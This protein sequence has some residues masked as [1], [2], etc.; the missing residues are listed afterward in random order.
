MNTKLL[1]QIESV[2]NAQVKANKVN[3]LQS[4]SSSS[5]ITLS[6]SM[7]T[8]T[9]TTPYTTT[10]TTSGRSTVET[11]SGPTSGSVFVPRFRP[12]TTSFLTRHMASRLNIQRPSSRRTFHGVSKHLDPAGD[13]ISMDVPAQATKVVVPISNQQKS[14]KP[15][16]SSKK[17]GKTNEECPEKPVQAETLVNR[18]QSVQS[19]TSRDEKTYYVHKETCSESSYTGQIGYEQ[20][21]KQASEQR[22]DKKQGYL[23]TAFKSA[24]SSVLPRIVVCVRKRPKNRAEIQRNDL[25]ILAI[26]NTDHVVICEPRQRFDLTEYVESTAFRFDHCF[27]ENATTAEVYEYT[28]APMVNCIFQGYMATCFAY[29]QTGSGKTFTMAGPKGETTNSPLIE[30]GIYGMVV[31]DLFACYK[32]GHYAERVTISVNFFEI[33]CNKVNDLLNAK[34]SLRVM[35]DSFGS[36]Q[37]MGLREYIVDDKKTTLALIKHGYLQR[38]NGRT[39]ANENSSRSHAIFQIN[40][41]QRI[42][43]ECPRQN[44][45]VDASRSQATSGSERSR[46]NFAQSQINPRLSGPLVGRFSLVDLAGNERSADGAITSDRI[47]HMES[48]EINKSLLAL[49][50]CIRAMG[51]NGTSYLPFRTSKLTQVL[52]ESFIGKRSKT[53]MIAT[54][55][56]GLSCYE[57][58]MN[59]LRYAQRVK[60]LQPSLSV[61]KRDYDCMFTEIARN[62]E[63]TKQAEKTPCPVRAR[64]RRPRLDTDNV[65]RQADGKSN[66]TRRRLRDQLRSPSESSQSGVLVTAKPLTRSP[67]CNTYALIP[68][69]GSSASAYFSPENVHDIRDSNDQLADY[70]DNDQIDLKSTEPLPVP[71]RHFCPTLGSVLPVEST[72]KTNGVRCTA[73]RSTYSR[74]ATSS[75]QLGRQSLN[76]GSRLWRV[77][78]QKND[79]IHKHK[80]FVKNLPKWIA[81][82]QRLLDKAHRDNINMLAYVDLLTNRLSKDISQL[83]T[84]QDDAIFLRSLQTQAQSLSPN[85]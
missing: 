43:D 74:S 61:E 53:C 2:I 26:P 31:S 1:E 38:T 82:H 45:P 48:G 21:E 23:Q 70:S 55:S 67:S 66:K 78:R 36:V 37:V 68:L 35:E 44:E 41:R 4:S 52:R 9:T 12:R 34:Q 17:L 75:A 15:T 42:S 77:Q 47:R 6:D 62:K 13:S 51:N 40:I 69:P 49:K 20:T 71:R 29:G 73:S 32:Q 7:S 81:E 60:H 24:A 65:Q 80:E 39:L 46:A 85:W 18:G 56:P 64:T 58:S 84:I 72:K 79:V 54:V 8:T 14:V 59:T 16:A 63:R 28:A 25:D 83:K 30:N 57:H 33:Y 50:E 10:T 11:D 22:I 76:G 3:L 5:T 27:D 19:K